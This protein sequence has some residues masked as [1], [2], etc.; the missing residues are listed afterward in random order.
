MEGAGKKLT[1]PKAMP[2]VTPS[3]LFRICVA[4]FVDH[5]DTCRHCEIKMEEQK[6]RPGM[7]V[8]EFSYRSNISDDLLEIFKEARAVSGASTAGEISESQLRECVAKNEQ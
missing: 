4:D 8:S 7:S 2:N 3:H 6:H 1:G 5:E